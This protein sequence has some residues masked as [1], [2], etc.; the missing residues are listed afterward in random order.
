[1]AEPQLRELMTG[2]GRKMMID[3][4]EITAQAQH[5]GELGAAREDIL[6]TFL[7]R[8]LPD[9]IGVDAGMIIDH[10]GASARQCDV[11]LYDKQ[12]APMFYLSEGKRIFPVETVLHTIEVKSYLDRRALADAVR[13]SRSVADLAPS[14]K[15]AYP[16]LAGYD[17]SHLFH[18][19][20]MHMTFEADTPGTSIFA[21]D[22]DSLH[23]TV[24]NLVALCQP[25]ARREWPRFVVSLKKGAVAWSNL[26][27]GADGVNIGTASLD[28]DGVTMIHSK[29]DNPL[30]PFYMLVLSTVQSEL[31]ARPDLNAYLGF[32]GTLQ[33]AKISDILDSLPESE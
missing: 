16:L 8:Y 9:R 11:I 14:T 3:F 19:P 23:T 1:M 15:P 21:F 33:Y 22:S 13:K 10:R 7:A 31:S 29:D 5:P 6:R 18:P 27:P 30:L 28:R 2:V 4:E 20:A 26:R 17:L 32:S 24:R 12:S 25:L